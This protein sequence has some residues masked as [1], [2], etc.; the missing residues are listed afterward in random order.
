MSF[1]CEVCHE[2]Q[3]AGVRPHQ[4]VT[5]VRKQTYRASHS[6]GYGWEIAEMKKVCEP[7]ST[8][9]EDAAVT[10]RRDLNPHLEEGS[11]KTTLAENLRYGAPEVKAP[12]NPEDWVA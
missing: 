1:R 11:L 10:L 2:A 8:K 3:D 7:C 4:V 5:K 12:Y 6:D 9:L